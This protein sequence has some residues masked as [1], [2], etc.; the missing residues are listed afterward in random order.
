MQ[1][2]PSDIMLKILFNLLSFVCV[3]D[4]AGEEAPAAEGGDDERGEP[5]GCH[6]I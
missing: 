5:S 3:K 2:P 6:G 1:S 4:E